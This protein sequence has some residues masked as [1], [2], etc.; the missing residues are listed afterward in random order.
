MHNS[1]KRTKLE[2]R[3][4][5][6]RR[7]QKKKQAYKNFKIRNNL[8]P[9]PKSFATDWNRFKERLKRPEIGIQIAIETID[10]GD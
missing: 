4:V 3:S 7:C 2:L 5:E 6:T 8:T 10:N 1:E 9:V